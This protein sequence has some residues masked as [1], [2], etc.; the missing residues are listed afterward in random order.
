[1]AELSCLSCD[2]EWEAPEM[3]HIVL[4]GAGYNTLG[5]VHKDHLEDALDE[6]DELK[7]IVLSDSDD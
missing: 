5:W 6:S 1:M 3:V 4:T 2:D 7:S